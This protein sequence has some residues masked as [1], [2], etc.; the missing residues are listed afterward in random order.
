MAKANFYYAIQLATQQNKVRRNY[1]DFCFCAVQ[2][3]KYSH[4]FL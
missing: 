3:V 4:Y 1:A 2:F